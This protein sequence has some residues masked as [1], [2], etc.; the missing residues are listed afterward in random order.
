VR[1]IVSLRTSARKE[2]D[3]NPCSITV[4]LGEKDLDL[5]CYSWLESVIGTMVAEI[6][7]GSV[8]KKLVLGD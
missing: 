7:Q 3:L 8:A 4:D 1:T 2:K 5:P 6:G